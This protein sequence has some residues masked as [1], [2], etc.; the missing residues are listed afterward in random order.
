MPNALGTHVVIIGAGI[1]GL[2][3]AKALSSYFEK[4]T[5]LERDDLPAGPTPRSGTP[6][7]RQVHLLL[8][9][10]MD[11]LVEFFPNFEKEL[12][13]AGAV[14][15]GFGSD[16]RAE[17]PGFDPFPQR[18]LGIDMLCM[19]R[20]LA[21]FVLRRAVDRQ[22]Q[23][24]L[25]SGCRVTE[26]LISPDRSAVS[27]VRYEGSDGI[28][29]EL[30]ADLVI[31]ASSRGTLTLGL[32]DELGLPRPEETE[33]A[34]DMRYATGMFE[35]PQGAPSD[36][37]AVVH[38]PSPATGRGGF[39][40]PIEN[41]LWHVGLNGVHGD[42]PPDRH[43]EFLAFA[44][45]LRTSTIYDAI[46]NATPVGVIHRFA[47]PSSVR[48]RFEKYRKFPSGLLP[49]ADVICR[50]NPAFGQ[51][52]SVA[53]QEVG[54]LSRLL[55][56]R[57]INRQGL[58]GIGPA[59]FDAI[60][61]VLATPWSVAEND[62]IY[63]KTRGDR[64]K[65]FERRLTVGLALLN[66]AA[67]DP[68]VHR[69]IAEVQHLKRPQSALR[70]DPMIVGKVRRGLAMAVATRLLVRSGLT[71]FWERNFARPRPAAQ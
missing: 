32:L 10:G 23:V 29:V 68:A 27:G 2:T 63:A 50:F 66:A 34:I 62:F 19:T 43:D 51:G 9:G 37:R 5:V 52:M 65:D 21:E 64:P 20:P 49:I 40:F 44:R 71:N 61:S 31:D 12:E 54:V 24:E 4:V 17:G 28:S 69:A 8:R 55:A 57:A 7:C 13:E 38:R 47:L 25:Q 16:I 45:S 53:A 6:Q 1:G 35:L 59:F 22:P 18:D 26:L 15:I 42:T 67:K 56:Q 60:Q 36:W 11:A 70:E 30:S 14:R 48:R 46:K 33:I 41:G 58:E 3:A 39:I